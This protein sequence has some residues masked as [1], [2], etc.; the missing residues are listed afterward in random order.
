MVSTLHPARCPDIRFFAEISGNRKIQW[1]KRRENCVQSK[2]TVWS[3]K[4][5][6]NRL[7]WLYWVV[8]YRFIAFPSLLVDKISVQKNGDAVSNKLTSEVSIFEGGVAVTWNNFLYYNCAP[9]HKDWRS[10]FETATKNTHA[11]W[12][13][14]NC[15][16]L[17]AVKWLEIRVVLSVCNFGE[18][19]RIFD[20]Q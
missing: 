10:V 12:K 19:V 17:I 20:P 16:E 14:K 15:T 13:S 5:V 8:L 2:N 18:L 1:K 3:S 7:F 11:I 4:F 6:R 9:G